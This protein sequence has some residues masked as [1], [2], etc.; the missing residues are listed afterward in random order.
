MRTFGIWFFGLLASAIVGALVG[1]RFDDGFSSSTGFWG[2]LA[3]MFAFACIKL[4]IG[5][6]RQIPS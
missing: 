5:G 2:M 4:W 1:S 6:S 3:G